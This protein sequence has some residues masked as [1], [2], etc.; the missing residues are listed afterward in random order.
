MFQW[1][2][3]AAAVAAAH[4]IYNKTR[5]QV[6]PRGSPFNKIMNYTDQSRAQKMQPGVLLHTNII[7][8]DHFADISTFIALM[9]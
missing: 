2:A 4:L 9:I 6:G 8:D 3:A 1:A 7:N 5:A